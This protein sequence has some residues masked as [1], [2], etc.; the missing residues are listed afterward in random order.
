MNN[1]L[2]AEKERL[3]KR[4]RALREV[5]PKIKE[6]L[7][8][9]EQFSKKD[10]IE[11]LKKITDYLSQFE[12]EA[13]MD[14]ITLKKLHR[15]IINNCNHEILVKEG[16]KNIYHCA[17]CNELFML[18]DIDFDCFLI[19]SIEDSAMNY[20]WLLSSIIK[21]IATNDENIMDIFESRLYKK[22]NKLLVYRRSR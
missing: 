13:R 8:D 10:S 17:I 6:L 4:H 21:E 1:K 2:I 9:R 15:D 16:I 14:F 12:E 19:E 20:F 7:K 5:I 18:D 22:N 3:S 11:A